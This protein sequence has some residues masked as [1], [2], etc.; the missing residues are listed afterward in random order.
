MIFLNKNEVKKASEILLNDGIIAFPTETVFGLGI[1]ASAK[2]YEKLVYVKNRPETKP[3]TLM[4]SKLN[5]VE[6]YVEINSLAKRII[7]AFTPGELTII[8]KAKEN[9]EHFMDLGTG[10]IGIR[11]PNN[12]YVLSLIDT[13]NKPL[14]VPSCNKSG[15]APCK[16]SDEVE[17]VFSDSIEACVEG[18]C[19]NGV[20]STIIKIVD[21]DIELI[22]QGKITLNEIK[23]K[24]L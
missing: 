24:V 22:R 21:N 19:E 15:E 4:I 18:K 20:P 12:K 2:N 11:I 3:F 8:L 1:I 16:D 23:E 17:K 13:V 9:V 6:E 10:F 5:Q 14:L 7:E